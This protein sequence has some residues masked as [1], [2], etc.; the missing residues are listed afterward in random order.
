M[1]TSRI[2]AYLKAEDNDSQNYL[3]GEQQSKTNASAIA[4]SES[5]DCDNRSLS[6]TVVAA[7][8]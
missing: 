6:F 7:G 5:W 2:E 3:R 1:V 8:L 4:Q